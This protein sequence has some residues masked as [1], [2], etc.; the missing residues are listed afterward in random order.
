MREVLAAACRLRDRLMESSGQSVWGWGLPGENGWSE[1][2]LREE[3]HHLGELRERMLDDAPAGVF[4]EGDE[5]EIP[6]CGG[7][8]RTTQ[9]SSRGRLQ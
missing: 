2:R 5:E 9:L 8:C 6:F 4:G 3:M 7:A 1:R